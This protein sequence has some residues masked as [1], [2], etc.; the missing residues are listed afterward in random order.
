[1]RDQ[2]KSKGQLIDELEELRFQVAALEQM[3]GEDKRGRERFTGMINGLL[4]LRVN[5]LENISRLTALCGKLLHGTFALYNRLEEGM[6]CSVS[7]WKVPA[8]YNPVAAPQ[9]Y[10]CFEVIS[11]GL[12]EATVVRDLLHT[13][14]A[15]TDPNVRKYDLQTYIGHPVKFG[16]TYTGSLCVVYTTD[17]LPTA[18]DKLLIKAIASAIAREEHRRRAEDALSRQILFL[19]TLMDGIP[20]PVFDKG[21]EGRYLGCNS[22]FANLVGLTKDE[23]VGKTVR[24]IASDEVSRTWWQKDRELFDHPHIQMFEY[25]RTDQNGV[26]QFTRVH[27]APFFNPDGALAGL[28]GVLVD[29]TDKKMREA[30]LSANLAFVQ[31]LIDAIP[32]PV[33][34]K[35]DTGRYLGCNK[36]FTE[37]V[38]HSEEEIIGKTVHEV[39]SNEFADM[40]HQ[41]DLGTMAHPG[42]RVFECPSR[43]SDGSLRSTIVSKSTFTNADGS[44]GGLIGVISDVT[45][46]KRAEEALRLERQQLLSI[47]DSIN[48]VISVVDTE[49]YEILY[50]NKFTQN[51]R[52]KELIG[53]SCFKALHDRDRPCDHCAMAMA[54]SL[55]GEPYR[56]ESHNPAN[57]RH[58][59]ATDRIIKWADGRD[60]KFH[61]GIDVTESKKAEAEREKTLSLLQATLE[62][63]ADG[64][65]VIDAAGKIAAY[66]RELTRMWRIPEQVM[67]SRNDDE[68]LGFV[69]NQLKYPEDFLKKV[70]DLYSRPDAESFDILEFKDGR[71]F[72]R[73][74]QPQRI[75]ETIIGRVWSFRDVTTRTRAEAALREREACLQAILNN[76]PFLMWLKDREGRFL[77]VN[78]V[79]AKSCGQQFPQ[80]VVGKT[81][82]DVWPADLAEGYRADDREV[83]DLKVQRQVE[84][85]V[86]DQGGV[87]WFET[88]KT[89]ILDEQG[90][91]VGTTGFARDITEQKGLQRQLLQAQKMEA[92]GTLAG[93]IAHDFNN[94]LQVTL[95]YSDLLLSEKSKADPDYAELQKIH[96]AALS[97][98]ELVKNLLMFSRKSDPEPVAMDLNKKIQHVEKLL[99]RTIPK[100]IDIRLDLA[101]G[102]ARINADSAQIEQTLMNLAVNAKDAIGEQGSLTIRTDNVTLDEEYCRFNIEAK[103]GEYVLLSVSDTGHGMDTETLRHVFEPFYTSKELGRGTGLGLAMVYGI[104]KQHGGHIECS[105]EVGEG[106][107]FKLYFPALPS[108]GEPAFER[109]DILPASGSETV[110]LVDDEDLVR[111]LGQR[112]L[113]RSGYTVL[114][115]TN[116]EEALEIYGR[117]KEHITLVILD[118]IM[119]A[120]GGKD[121]LKK[122]L[123][124]DPEAKVLVASG[125][126][127]DASTEEC[128]DRGA[129]GFVAKPFRVK[130]LLQ[131]VR[132]ALHEA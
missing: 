60:A 74:S 122:L 66:N 87:K 32:N 25:V 13:S 128:L 118:L 2:D 49:T 112:I 73:Y 65:L 80:A 91:V 30:E 129:K 72:E 55:Q 18:D 35:D 63:T 120:M 38:G 108:I 116:G 109:P 105:S 44:L 110:L 21:V 102:L 43:H 11:K 100:M 20:D 62:S 23:V 37:W 3:R 28:I 90:H 54:K 103:P 40:W 71:I 56:W 132:T 50:T 88:F 26:P 82:F 45:D 14:Y 79:F 34:Y 75:G 70:R 106:A 57:N 101:S 95:G 83:M 92:I 69:L 47:F 19:Q 117:E 131:Q 17:I 7:Q 113:M 130:E 33:F 68:A 81:D 67:E 78:D 127:P 16:E 115:A 114:M 53:C 27:K 9:G 126:S 42:I 84:E 111:E 123:E 64:I 52:G 41:Q 96:Q 51:L 77:A 8:D 124:I 46:L 76:A 125:Y 1:M 61:L 5:P 107:T 48:E 86:F 104:V 22:A 58:Y 12:D 29:I 85:Q 15:Q 10:I 4:D 94:L 119:P 36:A 31:T 99:H 39:A 121:C 93:G 24:D 6:L 89:P 97:G 98:A 59:L